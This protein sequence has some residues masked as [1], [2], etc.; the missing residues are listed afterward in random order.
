MT[1]LLTSGLR[2][3]TGLLRPA[4]RWLAHATETDHAVLARVAGPVIDIGCGPGRH[5]LALAER[6]VVTMGLDVTS[7]AVFLARARGVPVLER[8]VFERVPMAGRW[9]SALLLDGNIG[10]GGDPI[11]LLRR[12]AALVTEGGVVLAELDPPGFPLTTHTVR[13]ELGGEAGP[14][15]EWATVSVDQI[16]SAAES[17]GLEVLD[18]FATGDQWFAELRS[19]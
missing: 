1:D 12:V 16:T 17:S 5:A 15:F 3:R 9:R 14:W 19:G 4:A 7:P 11:T 10:I 6:G 13:L 2:C 8:S 18:V